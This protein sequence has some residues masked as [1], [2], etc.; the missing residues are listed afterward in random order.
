MLALVQFPTS[1]AY[2]MKNKTT[3]ARQV[4]ATYGLMKSYF[5]EIRNCDT[6]PSRRQSTSEL[7]IR[8]S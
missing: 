2:K 7:I 8:N 6:R 3:I 4:I 5:I 1:Y